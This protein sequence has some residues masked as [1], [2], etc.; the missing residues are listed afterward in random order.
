MSNLKIQ[1]LN[2]RLATKKLPTLRPGYLV[3]VHQKIKEGEKERVQVFEGIV[4]GLSSGN[5]VNKSVTVR[6]VVE[7]I[8]VEKIF[9]LASPNVVKIDIKKTFKVRRAKL[10]YMR[11]TANMS[12]RLKAKLGLIE[13]DEKMNKGKGEEAEESKEE[14]KSVE[15]PAVEEVAKEEAATEETKA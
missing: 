2:K 5:A 7:G 1:A 13:R 9:P 4:I 14:V 8:G 12:S 15:K 6:K 10:G 11:D 3:R